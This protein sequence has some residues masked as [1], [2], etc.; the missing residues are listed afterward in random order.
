[1]VRLLLEN[2]ANLIV[3]EEIAKAAASNERNGA[4]VFRALLNHQPVLLPSPPETE[5]KA[6]C[7]DYCD[8][9]Y[10]LTKAKYLQQTGLPYP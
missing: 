4:E 10:R 7:I 9:I 2:V 3:T 6:P 8:A 5:A 1:M